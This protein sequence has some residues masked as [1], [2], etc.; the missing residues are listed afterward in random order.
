MLLLPANRGG[1]RRHEFTL[2]VARLPLAFR[3]TLT[4]LERYLRATTLISD[5]DIRL[6]LGRVVERF[7]QAVADGYSITD[8]IGHD[9]VEF[10]DV[11]CGRYI[12]GPGAPRMRR[13]LRDA[14]DLARTAQGVQ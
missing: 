6:M 4:A 10:I 9:P 8:V 13:M 1:W 2:R 7:E 11:L 5:D 14:V 12:D 3:S